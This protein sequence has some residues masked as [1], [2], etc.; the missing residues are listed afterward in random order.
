MMEEIGH[1]GMS[2]PLS[3]TEV[4]YSLVQQTSA[5][6]DPISAQELYPPL[7]PIWAQ[8]SLANTDS[9]YL[10]LPS[11][12]AV[13]EAM[14][15]PDKPWEDLHH[16]SY[17]LPELS[18]IE[19]GEFT[20]TMTGDQPCPINLLATQEIYAEG[21]MVT[22]AATIP[23]NISRTP[24]IID[25]VFVR[26]YSSRKEM[27]GIDPQRVYHELT[28]LSFQAHFEIR[29]QHPARLHL[30]FSILSGL[31]EKS[32]HCGVLFKPFSDSL[33]MKILPSDLVSSHSL[34]WSR[35]TFLK[36]VSF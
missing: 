24:G 12:E 33:K 11:N 13:I 18:R 6:P 1:S 4:A 35:R 3:A 14:T 29:K 16:R 26:A 36:R 28:L 19:A 30:C 7:E 2:M 22:S 25:N 20:I 23:I 32:N 10:V 27:P 31:T 15:S 21:N 34:N 5:N 8:G 9:L 17:F